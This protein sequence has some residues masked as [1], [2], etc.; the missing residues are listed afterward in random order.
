MKEYL[1]EVYSNVLEIGCGDGSFSKVLNKGCVVWGI[2]PHI[3]SAEIAK[4]NMDQVLVGTYEDVFEKI[5]NEYF[6]LVIC[7]DVIEH[8]KN[9]EWFFSS[10]KCKMKKES[11]LVASIPNVRHCHNLFNLLVKKDWKYLDSGLLDRTHLRF[12]T[13]KSIKE[14]AKKYSF[15]INKFK[16]INKTK[17]PMSIF[18]WI[19]NIITIGYYWDIHYLQFA[20]TLQKR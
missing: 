14:T 20:M 9:H 2:E 6:D 19:L 10:I 1:P 4:S 7:N 5:P 11:F 3:S 13:E 12:F 16:G 17:F 15:K 8:M 18:C